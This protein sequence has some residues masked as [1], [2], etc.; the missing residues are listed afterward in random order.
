MLTVDRS[1]FTPEFRN[2]PREA[3]CARRCVPT[4]RRKVEYLIP[5]KTIDGHSSRDIAARLL[6]AWFG[7][8]TVTGAA[9]GYWETPGGTLT[10]DKVWRYRVAMSLESALES[11]FEAAATLAALL[12]EYTLYLEIG[13]E[14]A[15][16]RGFDTELASQWRERLGLHSG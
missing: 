9:V 1:H 8:A 7:G 4:F 15:F 11:A 14:H 5:E 6:S 12:N 3:F 16:A 10:K 13:T 2:A